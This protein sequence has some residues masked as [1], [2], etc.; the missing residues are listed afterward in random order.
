[1][2]R[3]FAGLRGLPYFDT[4]LSNNPNDTLLSA[5]LQGKSDPP[6]QFSEGQVKDTMRIY[7]VNE[8]QA[9]AVL[10]AMDPRASGFVLIQGFVSDC[11]CILCALSSL[12]QLTIFFHFTRY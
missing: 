5:V 8:P 10:A 4:L 11:I 6:L 3:E 7:A 12:P 1:M 2:H 9:K